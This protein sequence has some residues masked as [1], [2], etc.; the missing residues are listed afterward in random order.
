VLH[1]LLAAAFA[2]QEPLPPQQPPPPSQEALRV[3]LDCSSCDLDFVRTEITFVDWVRDRHDAQVYLLVT[4]QGTGAGGTEYTLT[5][6]GQEKFEGRAD[7]LRYVSQP[8]EPDD[9]V[10]HGLAHMMGLGLARY[11]AQTPLADEI[12]VRRRP[13]APG[14]PPGARAQQHDRWNFWVFRLSSN[15]NLQGE[16][17][18][19]YASLSNSVTVSRT[20]DLW[21]VYLSVSTNTDNTKYQLDSVNWY[22]NKTH[23][24]YY[25]GLVVRSVGA[26]WSAGLRTGANSSTYYNR[27]WNVSA[28]PAIEY[29]LWPYSQ[30]TRHLLRFNYGVS[31]EH[32]R[33]DTLTVY[34]K[35]AETLVKHS[36]EVALTSIQPWGTVNL[37][38]SGNQYLH[39]LRLWDYGVFGAFNL[40][41]IRGFSLGGGFSYSRIHDQVYLP[42][43][44][45]TQQQI[46]T[47]QIQLPTKYSYFTYFGLSFTFGSIFN[48]IVNPRFGS[49]GGGSSFCMCM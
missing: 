32:D 46:L 36:L 43:S 12:E 31:L 42:A 8:A 35:A 25:S 23:S 2:I 9:A 16:T 40:N 19:R 3:Y 44:S 24:Y 29:D 38:V 27:D 37:S 20:T 14:G 47:R 28:G 30:S 15:V 49:T 7:T 6:M 34:Q 48:S 39:D 11:V 4:T 10:R 22:V 5:L 18:Y 33:W 21:K 1:L 41:L 26:H 17:S 45:A 13:Q